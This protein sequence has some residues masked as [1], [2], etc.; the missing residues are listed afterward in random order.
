MS[1]T[2]KIDQS[3]LDLINKQADYMVA[4][5]TRLETEL[6]AVTAERDALK[7]EREYL[8]RIEAIVNAWVK[9]RT[10]TA[11]AFKAI[12]GVMNE[13]DVMKQKDGAK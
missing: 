10:T 4:N 3:V 8:R 6:A 11:A 9:V 2:V 5:F 7:A 13:R 12:Y 1:I